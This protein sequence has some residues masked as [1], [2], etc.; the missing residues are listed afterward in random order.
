MI[1][2]ESP[3]TF[4]PSIVWTF[5]SMASSADSGFS[6]MQKPNPLETCR[7]VYFITFACL[8]FPNWEKYFSNDSVC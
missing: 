4:L 6:N 7:S 8:I 2:M 5:V 1:C 3:P